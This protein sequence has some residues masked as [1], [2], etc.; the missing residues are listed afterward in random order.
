[1]NW[2]QDKGSGGENLGLQCG[3]EKVCVGE[4]P[5][6]DP[7]SVTP[8]ERPREVGILEHHG[9]R[10][11]RSRRLSANYIPYS[12]FSGAGGP[13]R[14]TSVLTTKPPSTVGPNLSLNFSLIQLLASHVYPS[15][16][17]PQAQH[18]QLST[19]FRASP[20][21][22][23]YSLLQCIGWPP[24]CHLKPPF[25]LCLHIQSV[26]KFCGFYVLHFY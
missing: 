7:C 24:A 21:K 19:H 12:R 23:P 17:K 8:G 5:Q 13:E 16:L 3:P 1:M 10:R 22:I 4:I 11:S 9:G 2:S 18:V 15:P 25:P 14:Y 20:L 26:T 6:G